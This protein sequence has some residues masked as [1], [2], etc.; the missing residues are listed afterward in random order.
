LYVLDQVV[1][2]A[3]ADA[4]LLSAQPV[5]VLPDQGS[6]IRAASPPPMRANKVIDAERSM[7]TTK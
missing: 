7:A 1:D 2:H 6:M 4:N 3:G 5:R